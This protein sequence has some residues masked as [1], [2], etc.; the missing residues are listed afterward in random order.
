MKLENYFTVASAP[1]NAASFETRFAYPINL[2]SGCTLALKS[3][4]YP[5]TKNITSRNNRVLVTADDR[6]ITVTDKIININNT[7]NSYV[8][9]DLDVDDDDD[10]QMHGGEEDDENLIVAK[11]V[12]DAFPNTTF[13]SSKSNGPMEGQKLL[14]HIRSAQSS[15]CLN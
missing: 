14:W 1:K 13:T 8:I 3:V 7:R 11:E 5:Q 10:I 9:P 6:N 15:P 2:D 12:E 4:F